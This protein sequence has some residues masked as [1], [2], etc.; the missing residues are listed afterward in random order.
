MDNLALAKQAFSYWDEEALGGERGAHSHQALFDLLADDVVFE[1]TCPPDTH[2]W[3][4]PI[5]GK[6]RVIE[7]YTVEAPAVLDGGGSD[8]S[9]PPVWFV[10]GDRVVMFG[11]HDYK[12]KKTGVQVRREFVHVLDFKDR[13]IAKFT[14]I[15]DLSEWYDAHRAR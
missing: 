12:I 2:L 14:V 11:E 7:H 8:L 10:N 1:V 6:Q 4:K 15:E 5:V 9:E 3:G 13:K